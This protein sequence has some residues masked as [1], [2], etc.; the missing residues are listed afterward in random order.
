MPKVSEDYL[1]SKRESIIEAALSLCKT[2]P[3]YQITMR[4]IIKRIGS[5]QGGIYR[6]FPDI[7]A[8]LVEVYNRCNPNADYR[9]NIDNI[10]ENSKS[11]KEAVEE[12]F[13][14][15]NRYLLENLNTV[16]KFIYELGVLMS[17]QPVRGRKI[18]SKI[19]DG[20]NG[21]YFIQKLY[22]VIR[23]GI[24]E[25]EFHP[26]IQEN[27][28]LSFISIAIDGIIFDGSLLLCYK[29]P[30][31]GE[32]PFDITKLIETLKTAVMLMLNVNNS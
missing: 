14:F 31:I 10:I 6:Y 26:V 7:D 3:L 18:Q 22:Q 1:N 19:K 23:E 5:S 11:H 2:M 27:D 20:Q 28:I 4:D 25:G 29:V 17:T 30:Q 13:S 12:L 9:N 32:V 8:I 21:Q 16:G 24:S 15:S